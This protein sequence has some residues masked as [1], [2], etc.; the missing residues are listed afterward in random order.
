V[1]EGRTGF[2]VVF[3]IESVV[4]CDLVSVCVSRVMG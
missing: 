3:E 4:R 1:V 2:V